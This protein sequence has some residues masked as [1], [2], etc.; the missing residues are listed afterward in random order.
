MAE[1]WTENSLKINKNGRKMVEKTYK[2]AAIANKIEAKRNTRKKCAENR[3][4]SLKLSQ[5]NKK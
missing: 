5:K 4:I 1:K 2:I 3:Q